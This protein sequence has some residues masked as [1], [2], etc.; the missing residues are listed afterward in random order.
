MF[1]NLT[2]LGSLHLPIKKKKKPALASTSSTES[3]FTHV[4]ESET[5][6]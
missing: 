6:F 3:Q 1:P 5:W 2:G 4:A